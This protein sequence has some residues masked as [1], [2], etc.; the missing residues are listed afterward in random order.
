MVAKTILK[1]VRKQTLHSG[2]DRII[3]FVLDTLKNA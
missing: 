2:T 3:K 1:V